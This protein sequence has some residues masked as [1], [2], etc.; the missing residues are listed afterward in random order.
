MAYGSNKASSG[1][2]APGL[3][4]YKLPVSPLQTP[5]V[6]IRLYGNTASTMFLQQ[7]TPDPQTTCK[8]DTHTYQKG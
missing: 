1:A 6:A 7:R 4:A 8:R 2:S 5:A 3:T